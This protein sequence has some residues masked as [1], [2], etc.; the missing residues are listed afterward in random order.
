MSHIMQR[1]ACSLA[2]HSPPPCV[3]VC[4]RKDSYLQYLHV[5]GK[6]SDV[7][8]A[9]EFDEFNQRSARNARLMVALR[10]RN[11]FVASGDGSIECF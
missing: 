2:G 5:V 7:P 3:C 8:T 4:Q 11:G 9:E 10:M 1:C 6:Q